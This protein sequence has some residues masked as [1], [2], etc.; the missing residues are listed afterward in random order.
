MKVLFISD[1]SLDQNSGGAQV[2]NDAIIKKGEELGH[3]I[4]LHAYSSPVDNFFGLYDVVV[5]S[6]LETLSNIYDNLPQCIANHH[7]HVRLEHD[8]CSYLK[9]EERKIL[10]ESAK[11]TFFLS[12][13]H[14]DF[15][16]KDY[17]DYFHDIEIVYDPIDPSLFYESNCEKEYDI[18]YCGFLHPLKG[19]LNLIRFAQLN[20]E[21]SIDIFGW[22]GSNIFGALPANCVMHEKVEHSQVA[23]IYRK[24]KYIYHSPVVREPFC[25][26]VAEALLCGCELIGAPEKIGSWLEF[27][28]VGREEFARKCQNASREF[29]EKI[30]P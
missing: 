16:K 28:K 11:K 19:T 9:S 5:S 22:G 4:I 7:K 23:D 30:E 24:S 26:M 27:H 3:E 6:N 12:Q 8:S 15:F 20:P 18:V 21:R 14:A 2:S 17:G 29:W 1:F 25:R 13:F 10:F